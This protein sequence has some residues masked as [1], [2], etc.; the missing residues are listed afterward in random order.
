[1][2]TF[3]H[4]PDWYVPFAAFFELVL[5]LVTL[6]IAYY[7]YRIWKL[8]SEANYLSFFAS[9]FLI[10]VSF[11]TRVVTNIILSKDLVTFNQTVREVVVASSNLGIGYMFRSVFVF[12]ALMILIILALKITDRRVISLLG[13]MVLLASFI[14]FN[15][16]VAFHIISIVLLMYIVAYFYGRHTAR[17]SKSGLVVFVSFLLITLSQAFYLLVFLSKAFFVVGHLTE[18]AGYLLLFVMLILVLNR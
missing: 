5:F 16:Y 2:I 9:F 10:A 3:L 18:L 4:A 15:A 14:S 7:S 8:T 11:L 12:A 17:R 1:M 13:I 6:G